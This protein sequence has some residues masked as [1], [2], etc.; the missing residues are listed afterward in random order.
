MKRYL[1][2]TDLILSTLG[3]HLGDLLGDKFNPIELPPRNISHSTDEEL[4]CK[5]CDKRLGS[6][7]RL[8]SHML[9][10]G[11]AQFQC[12]YCDKKLRRKVAL[13]IHEREHTGERPF[14]CPVCK[15]GFRSL[16]ALSSHTKYVH[17]ILTPRMKP[18]VQ[19]PKRVKKLK[20]EDENL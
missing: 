7:S 4:Q 5:V 3:A 1:W 19:R 10:H 8:E 12:S 18:I 15:K 16:G 14:V 17:K 9:R 20:V 6:K 2:Y 11:T 13:V